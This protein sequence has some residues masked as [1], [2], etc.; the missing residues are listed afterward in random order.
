MRPATLA[1]LVLLAGCAGKKQAESLALQ[2]GISDQAGP[3]GTRSCP[4]QTLS[5]VRLERETVWLDDTPW[6]VATEGAVTRLEQAFALCGQTDAIRPLKTWREAE[7]EAHE[8]RQQPAKDNAARLGATLVAGA[9]TS[10]AEEAGASPSASESQLAHAV[11][12]QNLQPIP[13]P[14]TGARDAALD[15]ARQALIDALLD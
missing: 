13:S 11:R 3:S 1:V 15:E 7:Q 10:V 5:E 6:S 14:V 12:D 4:W 2:G 9:V 8:A